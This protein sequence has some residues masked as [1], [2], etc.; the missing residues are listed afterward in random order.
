MRFAGFRSRAS[1]AACA[2]QFTERHLMNSPSPTFIFA[3]IFPPRIIRKTHSATTINEIPSSI[4]TAAANEGGE[5]VRTLM[6]IYLDTQPVECPAG[7]QVSPQY[8]HPPVSRDVG[9]DSPRIR[10][11]NA[12]SLPLPETL[13]CLRLPLC[14]KV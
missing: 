2:V 6:D 11:G 3:E 13:W 8:K 14:W 1:H 9:G 7:S 4:F 5:A 12:C 10:A